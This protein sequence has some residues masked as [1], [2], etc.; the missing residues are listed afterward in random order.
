MKLI[1]WK[2]SRSS[3]SSQSALLNLPQEVRDK[4][5]DCLI[6]TVDLKSIRLVNSKFREHGLKCLFRN[7]VCDLESLNTCNERSMQPSIRKEIRRLTVYAAVYNWN[8]RR[9]WVE[10][11]V[12]R[13]VADDLDSDSDGFGH[14]LRKRAFRLDAEDATMIKKLPGRC[15]HPLD[16]SDSDKSFQSHAPE[17]ECPCRQ[18]DKDSLR[19]YMSDSECLDLDNLIGDLNNIE[20]LRLNFSTS[21]DW[22]YPCNWPKERGVLD[23]SHMLSPN[24][25]ALEL[26]GLAVDSVALEGYFH[27]QANTLETLS[28]KNVVLLSTRPLFRT[29]PST[30]RFSIKVRRWEQQFTVIAKELHLKQLIL[31]GYL[32][33]D[34]PDGIRHIIQDRNEYESTEM[35]NTGTDSLLT[36]CL[37]WMTRRGLS[38]FPDSSFR[39]GS[40]YVEDLKRFQDKSWQMTAWHKGPYY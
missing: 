17:N 14:E 19:L 30:W 18:S 7:I 6:N 23:A 4:I 11:P 9:G 29:P 28:I 24:M 36:R 40:S 2:F 27:A 12:S 34:W 3:Q 35:A 15:N 21:L 13:P 10:A 37:K 8:E 33:E 22:P 39:H 20:S 5:I 31:R 38:P 32:I 26:E 25:R 16:D 1:D